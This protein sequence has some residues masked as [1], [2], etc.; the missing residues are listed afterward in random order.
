MKPIKRGYKL[1]CLASQ[2]G[3]IKKIQIYQR[4]DEQ[5]ENEFKEFGLGERVVLSLTKNEWG[6]KNNFFT[7]IPLLEKL[8]VENSLACGTIRAHRKG[9][10]ILHDDSKLA[11]GSSDYKITDSGIGVFK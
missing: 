6:K 3:Y 2:K 5:L 4:K 1:L 7:S 10:P 11:R 9:N 8:K